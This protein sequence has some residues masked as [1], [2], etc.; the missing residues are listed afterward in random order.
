MGP[1][2]LVHPHLFK[3]MSLSG[4]QC[5]NKKHSASQLTL[6]I[7]LAD[8]SSGKERTDSMGRTSKKETV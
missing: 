1:W 6:F 3:L 8:V 5:Y 2:S 4:Q 7:L